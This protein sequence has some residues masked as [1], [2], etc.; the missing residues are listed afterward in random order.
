MLGDDK[1]HNDLAKLPTSTTTGGNLVFSFKRN[2]ASLPPATPQIVQYSNDMVH[3]NEITV[4]SNSSGAVTVNPGSI[5]DHVAVT[6]SSS[7]PQTF[8]RL[9]VSE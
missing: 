3:W 8:V 5:F 9:K 7:D 6:I 1:N 4:P 2:R